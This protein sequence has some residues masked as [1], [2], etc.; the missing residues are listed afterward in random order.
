MPIVDY[1]AKGYFRA[2]EENKEVVG[3]VVSCFKECRLQERQLFGSSDFCDN[4][5]I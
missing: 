2:I 1:V 3:C 4:S 5:N